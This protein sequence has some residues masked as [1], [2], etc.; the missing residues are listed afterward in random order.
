M[1]VLAIGIT[2]SRPLKG[3][4]SRK[5]LLSL[6]LFMTDLVQTKVRQQFL[7]FKNHSPKS[8]DFLCGDILNV[9][10]VHLICQNSQLSGN[11]F[12]SVSQF[13]SYIYLLL[14]KEFADLF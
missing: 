8:Y 5:K 7:N 11:K 9:K 12:C 4:F 13:L 2:Y 3:T 14:F 6:L 10:V 1:L